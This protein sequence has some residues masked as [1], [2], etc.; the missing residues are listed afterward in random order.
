MMRRMPRRPFA[1]PSVSVH[2]AAFAAFA[3]FVVHAPPAGAKERPG[4]APETG[5]GPDSVLQQL[6]RVPTQKA[7][8]EAPPPPPSSE[9]DMAASWKRWASLFSPR[10]QGV[11]PTKGGNDMATIQQ[12][13]GQGRKLSAKQAALV[14]KLRSMLTPYKALVVSGGVSLGSYQAG[15]LYYTT[16]ILRRFD[17][18]AAPARLGRPRRRAFP[19][20]GGRVGGLHQRLPEL[21]RR[22]PRA[23][24]RPRAEPIL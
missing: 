1:S 14:E 11:R 4:A 19:R 5:Q 18:G 2:A 21:D 7:A 12:A 20:G 22:M 10:L 16:L 17:D 8:P 13:R 9:E 3:A 15:F 24:R 6:D 23:R